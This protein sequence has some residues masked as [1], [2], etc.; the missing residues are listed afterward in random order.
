MFYEP[1]MLGKRIACLQRLLRRFVPFASGL[2]GLRTPRFALR[3]LMDESAS[4]RV[5]TKTLDQESTRSLIRA[6][7]EGEREALGVLLQRLAPWLERIIGQRWRQLDLAY[8]EEDLYSTI[9]RRAVRSFESFEGMERAQLLAWFRELL[10]NAIFDLARKALAKKRNRDRR[11]EIGTAIQQLP[12]DAQGPATIAQQKD[13]VLFALSAMQSLTLADRNLLIAHD[14]R[15]I[16]L[17][18]LQAQQGIGYEVLKK[19]LQRARKKLQ[20]I[21]AEGRQGEASR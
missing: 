8:D 14:I 1:A 4:E 12:D 3:R 21:I 15:S 20:D 18:E 9:V 7:R 17:K 19:R 6:A 5:W 16:P 2:R 13:E 11:V 10:E